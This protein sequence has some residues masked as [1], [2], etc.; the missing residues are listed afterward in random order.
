MLAAASLWGT[1][2]TVAHFAPPGSSQV[3]VGLSTF[4]FGGLVLLGLDVRG[5]ARVLSDRTTWAWLLLGA[6]GVGAY[7][8]C[9][10]WS[11]SLVGVAV[12]NVLAL[13]SGPVFAALLELV[14]ERRP[15]R[16]AWVAATAVSVLG[17]ALLSG[18]AQG[19]SG[20]TSAGGSVLAGVA[21]GLV[22]GFGYALY[23]WVAARLIGRGHPSRSVMA[24][25]FTVAS[26]VLLPVFALGS[27]GPLLSPP[28][29][30]VLAYL[31]LLPM[32]VAYLLFGY[33]LRVLPASTAT[34]LALAEPVVATGLAVVVIGERLTWPGWLGISL[35]VCGLLLVA[36]AERVAD[37]S[38]A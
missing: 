25:I 11:M 3:L 15:L 17:I 6:V 33:G 22:A 37:P 26:V 38:R 35:I 7:A 24:G 34:T 31:A 16:R 30:V 19:G 13:G 18:A 23:S 8:G 29:L 20:G 10:Y 28:G 12:G 32:A 36:A 5:V 9:Y 14:V 4:G 1:T 21:L 2:G 27:P